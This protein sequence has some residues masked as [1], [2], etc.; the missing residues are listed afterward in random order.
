[1]AVVAHYIDCAGAR[2]HVLLAIRSIHGAHTADNISEALQGVIVDFQLNHKERFG[3]TVSDNA[4]T[5][6]KAVDLLLRSLF[7]WMTKKQRRARRLR[8]LGHV[9]NVGANH[10]IHGINSDEVMQQME[11]ARQAND[12]D[13]I[14]SLWRRVGAMGVLHNLIRYIR[15]TPQRRN[16]F[17]EVVVGGR[18]AHYDGLGVSCPVRRS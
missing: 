12:S 16:E 15:M 1:M 7:P 2:R 13:R 4:Q 5:N 3:W 8:C 9:I 14:A 11:D 10:F 18:D 6:D 17:A